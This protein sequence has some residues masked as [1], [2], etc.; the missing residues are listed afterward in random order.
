MN[1]V[2]LRT[3]R[4]NPRPARRRRKR[5]VELAELPDEELLGRYCEGREDSK[6]AATQLYLRYAERMFRY[7]KARGL[8]YED[9]EDG[10]ETVFLRVLQ[11]CARFDPSRGKVSQWIYGIAR[12]VLL[13][14]YAELRRRRREVS[15]VGNGDDDGITELPDV[16]DVR[17]ALE[18]ERLFKA[19]DCAL[20]RL[21]PEHWAGLHL[22]WEGTEIHIGPGFPTIAARTRLRELYSICYRDLEKDE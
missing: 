9:A 17:F 3:T 21:E 20:D 22:S 13:E 11:N 12:L 4:A 15:F 16:G 10:Q 1:P 18:N 5:A 7:F 8:R 14:F 19:L 6:A 2:R